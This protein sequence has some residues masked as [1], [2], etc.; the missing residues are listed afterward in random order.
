MR[1]VRRK[2]LVHP[3]EIENAVDLAHQVIGRHDLVEIKRIKELTL[4]TF[5]PTHHEPLP[6]MPVAI[7]RNHR[8]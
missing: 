4:S 6:S 8:S 2:L 7:Q 3:T 1:V 5:S